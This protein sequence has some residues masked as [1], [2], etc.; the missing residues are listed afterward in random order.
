MSGKC[1]AAYLEKLVLKAIDDLEAM[2]GRSLNST[3]YGSRLGALV[4]KALRKE[5]LQQ[6]GLKRLH[7]N[8]TLRT[9]GISPDIANE[10]IEEFV[11]KRERWIYDDLKHL[12]EGK[13]KDGTVYKRK[14]GNMMPDFM[15]E[16]PDGNMVIWDLTSKSDAEHAAKTLLYQRIASVA[17]GGRYMQFTESF[18]KPL[19]PK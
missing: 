1:S 2:G 14:I 3:E 9:F 15:A 13:R 8:R 16:L 11:Y 10:T 12:F 18:W 6:M 4:N 17:M 7:V 19:R 5:G